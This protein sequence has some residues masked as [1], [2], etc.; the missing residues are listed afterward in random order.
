MGSSNQID[1]IDCGWKQNK[2]KLTSA[3]F[4]ASHP[5]LC[6]TREIPGDACCVRGH[7]EP[8]TFC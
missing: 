8:Y 1:G 4:N 5:K 6:S 2:K 3:I 7:K